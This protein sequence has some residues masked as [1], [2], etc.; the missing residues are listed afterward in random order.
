MPQSLAAKYG[1]TSGPAASTLDSWSA[2]HTIPSR[3]PFTHFLPAEGLML[4]SL[5][6]KYEPSRRSDH[7]LKLKRWVG[8]AGGCTAQRMLIMPV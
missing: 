3:N 8:A 6:T 5:A 7:W 2:R 4:K 1:P